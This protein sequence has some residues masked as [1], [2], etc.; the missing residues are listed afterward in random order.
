MAVF[1]LEPL[2][3]F[4]SSLFSPLVWSYSPD[5]TRRERVFSELCEPPPRRLLHETDACTAPQTPP[6]IFKPLPATF[7]NAH[8]YDAPAGR[9]YA[10]ELCFMLHVIETCRV[11]CMI[12]FVRNNIFFSFCLKLSQLTIRLQSP[13]PRSSSRL[14]S[15]APR[16]RFSLQSA[17][18]L[19]HASRHLRPC[20][21]GPGCVYFPFIVDSP[22]QP[23][24]FSEA[25]FT[26]SPPRAP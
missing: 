3:S 20:P 11:Q 13:T 16:Q 26:K 14:S 19:L 5:F 23:H 7:F 2:I 18:I 4:N 12:L 22:R 6:V 25:G 24:D 17:P 9:I 15:L 8:R 21:Q 10:Q 1:L